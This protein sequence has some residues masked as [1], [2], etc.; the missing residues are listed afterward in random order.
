MYKE[1]IKNLD[2]AIYGA[3]IERSRHEHLAA[4]AAEEAAETW[5]TNEQPAIA[6]SEL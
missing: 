6:H 2:A 4:R 3:T 5:V 1:N